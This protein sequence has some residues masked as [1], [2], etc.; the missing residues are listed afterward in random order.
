MRA[1]WDSI[2]EK[3]RGRVRVMKIKADAALVKLE[4]R[5]SYILN[6][7]KK[8][9]QFSKEYQLFVAWG[10][11]FPGPV[12]LTIDLSLSECS[13]VVHLLKYREVV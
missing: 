9:K 1:T 13:L 10:A 12:E 8:I 2:Y 7:K 5:S 4:R 6:D 3:C 11:F